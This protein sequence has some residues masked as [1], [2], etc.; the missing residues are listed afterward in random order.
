MIQSPAREWIVWALSARI[1]FCDN[2]ETCL[3]TWIIHLSETA[4]QRGN[5]FIHGQR[6]LLPSTIRLCILS[7]YIYGE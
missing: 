1:D 2:I 5:D 4:Q 3:L 6:F 7:L